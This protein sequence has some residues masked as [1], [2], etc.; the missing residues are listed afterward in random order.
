MPRELDWHFKT[1][2]TNFQK[3]LPTSE[4]HIVLQNACVK[5]QAASETNACTVIK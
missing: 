2:A 3:K 4:G 1:N 5:G